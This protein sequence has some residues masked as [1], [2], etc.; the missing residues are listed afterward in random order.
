MRINTLEKKSNKWMI[1]VFLVFIIGIY[2]SY[3]RAAILSMVIAVGAYYIIK[4]Q[5]VK[6]AL[7]VSSIVAIIGII[8]LAW[9]NKYMD[10][11]T[12]F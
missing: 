1:L 2:F 4:M 3:T 6:H 8:F 7:A 11:C 10:F 5:W 12:Q 9:D